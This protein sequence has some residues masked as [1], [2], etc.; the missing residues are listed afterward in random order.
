MVLIHKNRLYLQ[1]LFIRGACTSCLTRQCAG[2]EGNGE[3]TS[4]LLVGA[5][6]QKPLQPPWRKPKAGCLQNWSRNLNVW[7]WTRSSFRIDQGY[8]TP[9]GLAPTAHNSSLLSI[10]SIAFLHP[11]AWH[12]SSP[13]IF[14]NS[15]YCYKESVLLSPSKMMSCRS[16][17]PGPE[18]CGQSSANSTSSWGAHSAELAAGLQARRSTSGTTSWTPS[19]INEEQDQDNHS[20]AVLGGTASWDHVGSRNRFMAQLT[21]E[22]WVCL[23]LKSAWISAYHSLSGMFLVLETILKRVWILCTFAFCVIKQFLVSYPVS[24]ELCIHC[25]AWLIRCQ[26]VCA[27]PAYHPMAG[28]SAFTNVE[29]KKKKSNNRKKNY[30]YV[31]L[32]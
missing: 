26:D 20:N 17:F 23:E 24:E 12:C 29:R 25:F 32:S 16:C 8:A 13:G 3:C 10:S 4:C 30:F 14:P 7:F 21:K 31:Y 1:Q 27:L 22:V 6:K 19:L 11:Q 5:A 28:S 9:F 2:Q 18:L 15:C